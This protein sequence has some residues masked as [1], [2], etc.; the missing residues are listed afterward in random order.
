METGITRNKIN[1][2][3]VIKVPGNVGGKGAQVCR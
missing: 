1:N 3:L 2:S